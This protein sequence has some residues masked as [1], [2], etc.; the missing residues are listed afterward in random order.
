[1]RCFFCSLPILTGEKVNHHHLV[2]KSRGG[3][4]TSPAHEACHR[5]HHQNAGDFKAWGRE[6]GLI[7]ATTRRWAVNLKN[8]STHPAYD[9]DRAYYFALYARA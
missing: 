2:Y 6:G 1:M 7:T 9:L 8:V 3:V 4:D 5:A